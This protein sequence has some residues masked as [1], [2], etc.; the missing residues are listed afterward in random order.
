MKSLL[1]IFFCFI[2]IFLFAQKQLLK[3]N[4]EL[5]QFGMMKNESIIKQNYMWHDGSQKKYNIAFFSSG[6]NE[7]IIKT[8]LYKGTF[9]VWGHGKKH[10]SFMGPIHRT[11]SDEKLNIIKSRILEG[12]K[13]FQSEIV[14]KRENY[15]HLDIKLD[16]N[17]YLSFYLNREVEEFAFWVDYVKYKMDQQSFEGFLNALTYYFN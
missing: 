17:I 9:E 1:P 5:D 12:Y 11:Y 16:D 6:I 15:E 8:D 7:D 3:N 2:P 13:I 10:L 4:S 14:R